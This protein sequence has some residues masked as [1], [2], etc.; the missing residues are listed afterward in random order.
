MSA[1]L[2]SSTLESAELAPGASS[3]VAERVSAP[4]SPPKG[5]VSRAPVERQGSSQPAEKPVR[6]KG[7]TAP[8]SP[9]VRSSSTLAREIEALDAVQGSLTRRDFQRAFE[10]AERYPKDFPAGQ[11]GAEA[12]ALAIEALAGH[13]NHAEVKRRALIFLDRYPNDP[14]RARVAAIIER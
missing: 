9:S 13:G 5:E 3:S 6:N 14:H 8:S 12:A 7:S 11:L 10:L 1:V 4:P 2:G